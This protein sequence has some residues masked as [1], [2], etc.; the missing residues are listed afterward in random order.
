MSKEE[1]TIITLLN[2]RKRKIIVW[3]TMSGE[4]HHVIDVK[5]GRYYSEYDYYNCLRRLQDDLTK[6][7]KASCNNVDVT[8]QYK[9]LTKQINTLIKR[10]D[11]FCE[12]DN[13]DYVFSDED[14]IRNL[15]SA[16]Q[17]LNNWLTDTIIKEKT[18]NK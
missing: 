3:T 17:F 12:V 13:Y 18:E 15:R 16:I 10:L 4:V 9:H 8:P 6:D 11:K 1:S 14:T 7:E 5:T 2:G